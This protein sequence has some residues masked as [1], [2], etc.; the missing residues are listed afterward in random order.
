MKPS[1]KFF[2]EVIEVFK[3]DNPIL[4]IPIDNKEGNFTKI[5]YSKLNE[6]EEF[7]EK[8][9]VP[10][11]LEK[12]IIFNGIKISDVLNKI[13]TLNTGLKDSIDEYL[14]GKLYEANNVFFKTLNEVN[15]EKVKLEREIPNGNL[16]F[17]ARPK[18]ETQFKK[19]ELFHIPFE[20]RTIVST[21]RYSIPGIPALYLGDNSYTCWEEFERPH[22][23]DLSFSVFENERALNI[24][25]ILR[26]ND[27]LKEIEQNITPT[28]ISF[29]ILKF[30]I[31][32]PLSIA[33][34]IK[35]YDRKGNFKPEYIIPQML[36]EYVVRN[37]KI[38]GIKF[39]STKI[40]Y[41]NLE[42]LKA[43]NYIFPI[44]ENQDSGYCPVL[45]S[46][47]TLTEPTSLNLEELLDNPIYKKTYIYT[48]KELAVKPE[49]ITLIKGEKREYY[50]TSFGKLDTILKRKKRKKL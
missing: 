36:L 28:F 10:L 1:E 41:A 13:K 39:P 15:Y 44:R 32:F 31:Y 49:K 14:N 46:T 34:T 23:K 35:V 2:E 37:E 26:L 4:E 24:I 16:F 21:N 6:Y 12:K 33:C 40:N 45:K 38:D 50:N 47:F 20:R 17:R 7:F 27:M 9:I 18:S 19:E 5:L 42:N 43:Y 22:F 8:K 3:K 11:T 48:Q 25:Q 29:E 30:F